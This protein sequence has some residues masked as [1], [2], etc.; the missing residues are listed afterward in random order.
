M[1]IIKKHTKIHYIT[2]YLKINTNM[3]LQWTLVATFLYAEVGFMCILL[4]PFI[5]PTRWQKILKSRLVQALGSYASIYFNVILVALILLL[6]DAIREISKY[7]A[8]ISNNHDQG[9][10]YGNSLE[11]VKEFRAQRNFY[12]AGTALLLWFVIKRILALIAKSAQLIAESSAAKSQAE[13][14]SRTAAAL[15]ETSSSDKISKKDTEQTTEDLKTC[16][17]SKDDAIVILE[18]ELKSAEKNVQAMKKQSENVTKE[19]DNLLKEHAKVTAK[20]DRLE[21]SA[22]NNKDK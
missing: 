10:G 13:S 7:K 18:K 22:E 17:K 4:L 3:S 1:K 6:L 5:S 12:I 8:K 15:L 21:Y 19:Y 11:L 9:P 20:L 16:L 14:A 2:Y